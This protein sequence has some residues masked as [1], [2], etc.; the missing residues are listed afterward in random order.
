MMDKRGQGLP[1]NTIIIALLV[2]TVL[3]VVVVIFTGQ[4]KNFTAGLR[5]C[6]TSGGTCEAGT[7]QCPAGYS[8]APL[9]SCDKKDGKDQ[10]CCIKVEEVKKKACVSDDTVE[11][12]RVIED[13]CV[14]DLDGKVLG[15]SS[16]YDVGEGYICCEWT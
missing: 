13:V 15:D 11:R 7:D 4:T 8:K 1:L 5:D 2:I 9:S 14:D 6:A 16:E 12:G 3:V 10:T